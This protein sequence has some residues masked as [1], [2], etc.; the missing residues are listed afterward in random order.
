MTRWRW[1]PAAL[2]R[3]THFRR[4]RIPKFLTY[5]ERVLQTNPRAPGQH[6]VGDGFTYV[7]LTLFQ[8]LEGLDYAFP[9]AFRRMVPRIPGLMALRQRVAER[10]RIAAY[11]RSERR[12]AFNERCIFRRYPELDLP[13]TRPA[14][15][16]PPH[17]RR[18]SRTRRK[19]RRAARVVRRRG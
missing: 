18:V 11:L 5:F 9:H 15:A 2:E 12:Q 16:R 17:R 14:K 7:E 10:P 4:E 1:N 8:V 6:L 13:K 3:S 19:P